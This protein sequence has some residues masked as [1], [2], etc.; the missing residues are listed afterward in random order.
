[1]NRKNQAVFSKLAGAAASAPLFLFCSMAAAAPKP[2][3]GWSLPRDVST[4]GHQVDWLIN[5]TM[6]FLT[7]MFVIMC[8]WMGIACLKHN[9]NHTAEYDHGNSAHSVKTALGLSA[10]IFV[11]VD[12]NLWLDSTADMNGV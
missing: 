11:I 7:I 3:S 2:E 4:Y 1:M 8:V 9:K 6:V 10:I 5:I 12:G